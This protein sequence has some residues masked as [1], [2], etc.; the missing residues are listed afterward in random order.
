MLP[1][2]AGIN[3]MRLNNY[4]VSGT[5][6]SNYCFEI[7]ILITYAYSGHAGMRPLRGLVFNRIRLVKGEYFQM[8]MSTE[9]TSLEPQQ[10]PLGPCPKPRVVQEGVE[11]QRKLRNGQKTVNLKALRMLPPQPPSPFSPPSIPHKLRQQPCHG[12]VDNAKRTTRPNVKCRHLPE[13]HSIRGLANL[14][15]GMPGS[16][17]CV[18]STQSA[19]SNISDTAKVTQPSGQMNSSR[20]EVDPH[21]SSAGSAEAV[22]SMN[23]E[24]DIAQLRTL[25][26]YVGPDAPAR[27]FKFMG[28]PVLGNN[29]I[30]LLWQEAKRQN[31]PPFCVYK[32]TLS[33]VNVTS[34]VIFQRSQS[35]PD[36]LVNLTQNNRAHVMHFAASLRSGSEI[37][38]NEMM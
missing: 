19:L 38:G 8:N 32:M 30:S 10:E 13:V 24:V 17:N 28:L 11:M 14:E 4:K 15:W 23:G 6:L 29:P 35:S 16:I 1:Q 36:H 2:R 33:G 5:G 31:F 22:E 37:S 3:S 25:T 20:I 27:D 9:Y 7:N 26:A 34:T 18:P 12:Q 21:G